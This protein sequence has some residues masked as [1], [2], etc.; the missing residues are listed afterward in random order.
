MDP[1]YHGLQPTTDEW[2]LIINFLQQ[3]E[4]PILRT[5]EAR[6][7][8]ANYLTRTGP[9]SSFHPVWNLADRPLAFWTEACLESPELGELAVRIFN[10]PANS[11]PSERAFSTQNIIHSKTRS[12][13]SPM[14]TNMLAYIHVNKRILDRTE[15]EI[16]SW[17]QMKD[18]E[19][20]EIEG[21]L[22]HEIP[23]EP[24]WM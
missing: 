24:V 19:L 11:V 15:T 8:I 22:I 3:Y 5:G 7:Q 17:H 4:N 9:F 1:E 12:N 23:E 13:L 10:T 14:L 2:S 21:E 6:I 16:R 20:A 18:L